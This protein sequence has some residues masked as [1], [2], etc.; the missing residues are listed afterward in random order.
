[1]FWKRYYKRFSVRVKIIAYNCIII[2]CHLVEVAKFAVT[3]FFSLFCI[4]VFNIPITH[5]IISFVVSFAKL[6]LFSLFPN[7][8]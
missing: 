2:L 5:I 6:L 7:F 3:N 8:F 4:A 1:M